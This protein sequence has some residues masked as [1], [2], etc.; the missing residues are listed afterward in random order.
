MVVST[1][2]FDEFDVLPNSQ[3]RGNN[4]PYDNAHPFVNTRRGAIYPDSS[5]SVTGSS[6]TDISAIQASLAAQFQQLNN[7]ISSLPAQ[8]IDRIPHDGIDP[9]EKTEFVKKYQSLIGGLIWIQRQTRPD[10]STV[11][12]LLASHNSNPSKGH[13]SAAKHV[14]AYLKGTMDRGIRFTQGGATLSA[15]VSFPTNDGVYTDAGWGP[16]DASHPKDGETVE[17]AEVQSLLGHIVFRQGG[18]IIWNSSR[19]VG[20]ISGSSCES[21]IY[22]TDEGTKSVLAVRHLLQDL[23]MPDGFSTTMIWNDN[24]GCVDWTKGVTV[25][26]KLRHV[27]MRNLRV[28][29]S[30]RLG[31]I[32][33]AHIDGKRNI[34]DIMTKEIK[35]DN[36]SSTWRRLLRLHECST[37]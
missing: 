5:S 7:L 11:T 33:V 10:I 32:S 1:N 31:E 22:A 19:E 3:Q 26:R 29:L 36:H 14:L 12:K 4:F 16:Q 9:K 37:S 30:Q 2:P 8:H 13:Y 6:V 24:R 15:H 18:P 28:R 35:D 21:E 34:A 25:S 27:N 23:D 20:T 17:E